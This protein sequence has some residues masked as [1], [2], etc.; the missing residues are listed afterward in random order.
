V[1]VNPHYSTMPWR[2]DG[3]NDNQV[4][5]LVKLPKGAKAIGYNWDFKTKIDS[6]GNVE[7]YKARLVTKEFTQQEGINYYKTFSPVSKKDSFRIIM[8]LVAYF[9]MKL[10]Q[11]DVKTVFLNWDLEE[12]V[13]MKQLD[14]FISNENDHMVC[15]LKKSIYGIKQASRQWY[16]KFHNI[17]SSFGFM[18]NVMNQCIYHKV[19][20]SKIIFLVLYVDD[21]LLA[22]RDLGLLHEAKYFSHNSLTWKIWVKSLILLA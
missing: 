10:H 12:K 1:E 15:K 7:R 13:D 18:E 2:W 11:M 9:D 19:S 8:I 3:F 20:G 5:D 16:L 22:S 4:W 6:L 14:G 21:I 17:I